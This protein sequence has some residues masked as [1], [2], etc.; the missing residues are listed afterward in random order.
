MRIKTGLDT[1]L[2]RI[3]ARTPLS[4]YSPYDYFKVGKLLRFHSA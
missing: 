2:T 1:Y 4:R 3:Q